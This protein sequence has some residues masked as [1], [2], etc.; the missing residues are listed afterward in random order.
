[1]VWY[2]GT[3]AYLWEHSPV[4]SALRYVKCMR[5]IENVVALGKQYSDDGD[6]RFAATLLSHAVFADQNND[7]AKEALQ[8]VHLQLGYGAKMEHDATFTLRGHTSWIIPI[9]RRDSSRMPRH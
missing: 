8:S 9:G 1:M 6:L 3:P 7:S 5:G 4:P 2:D